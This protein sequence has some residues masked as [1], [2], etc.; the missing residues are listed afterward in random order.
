MLTVPLVVKLGIILRALARQHGGHHGR[1]PAHRALPGPGG[2][3]SDLCCCRSRRPTG[4]CSRGADEPHPGQPWCCPCWRRRF[5][6]MYSNAHRD[7]ASS[8]SDWLQ[9][10]LQMTSIARKSINANKHVIICGYGR[11]RAEPGAHVGA[12]IHPLHGAGPGSRPRAPS[13]QGRGFG[14]V[15]R[16]STLA[17]ADGGRSGTASAVVV[18]YHDTPGALK[19]LAKVRAHAP[20]VPVIVRTHD[21]HDLER[22]R[23]AAPQ[24]SCP[25]PSRAP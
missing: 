7:E 15:R 10:S 22:L 1:G 13:R 24:R 6:I 9:Q 8:A 12:R 14:G 16:C 25:R 18:T 4:W 20:Q 2:G 19:V 3:S 21:D 17:G 11:K 5:I 23:Q